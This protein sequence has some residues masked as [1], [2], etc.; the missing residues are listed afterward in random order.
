VLKTLAALAAIPALL[1]AGWESAR[2]EDKPLYAPPAKWVQVAS[3][4]PTPDDPQPPAIQALLGDNQTMI[5]AQGVTYYNRRVA[6]IAKPEGLAGSG[7]RSMT[8]DPARETL[9][10][11]ALTIVR[12][13]KTIDLLNDGKDVLVLRREK[14]LERAMLDGRMTA[15][16]QLKDLQVGDVVDWSYSLRHAEPLLGGRINDSERMTWAGAIGRYRVRLLWPDGA[17][18]TWKTTT[19]FPAPQLS[20]TGK[21]HELLVD[22]ANAAAPKPPAGAPGRFQRPGELYASTYADWAEVSR[23]MAPLYAQA[24]TLK[25]DSPLKAEAARI[26]AASPDPKVR[27]FAALDLVEDKTRYLLL[28]M[29]DG[30]Y[31][32]APADETWARRFGDCKGKTVLLLALLRELGIEAE[33][34]L[35]RAGD[36]DGLDGRVASAAQFNHVLVRARI[37]GADYWLD[38]TRTGDA[39]GLDA[40]RPPG[41]QWALPVREAGAGLEPIVQPPLTAPDSDH[42]LRFDASA[43]L[44]EPAPTKLTLVLRG[45]KARSLAR[46]IETLPRAD[47][48]RSLKQSLSSSMSWLTLDT[49]DWTIAPDGEVT[50]AFAG[51]AD[52]DW[53]LN[54]D[55]GVREFRLPGTGDGQVKTFPRREPGPDS[56]APYAVGYPNFVRTVTEIVLPGRGAGFSVKGP[57]GEATIGGAKVSQ[58]SRLVDGVAR[59][60]HTSASQLREIPFAAAE[61]SNK[62]LRK[63]ASEA[64][65]VRA[66]KGAEQ[67]KGQ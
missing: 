34:A 37:A 65:I 28:A 17:P 23:R 63:A 27:A 11:H 21:T 56:D 1:L 22:I 20:M 39:G 25:P 58:S 35:V 18:L 13:G 5:D 44:D 15:S 2:A 41:F 33:P 46:L 50:V 12:D 66:P 64:K 8:W 38:G 51:K 3:I 31:R 67:P 30:G 42:L 49:L 60:E 4:P 29:G 59:F 19:G 32:P 55:L 54:D 9:T 53:A 10:L 52:M 62:L 57:N 7:S 43:G 14:N 6:R 61:P 45:D 26:A 48:E 16:I 40:L 24:A 47:L 36:G